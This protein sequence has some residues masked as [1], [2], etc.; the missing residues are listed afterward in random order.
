MDV[1]DNAFMFLNS[2]S[3]AKVML[4]ASWTEWKNLFSFEV[5]LESAKFE[6]KGLGGS[7]GTETLISHVMEG[8]L[9]IPTQSETLFEGPDLSWQYEL[10]DVEGEIMGAD[11][12]KGANGD[13]S[14]EVL[15]IVDKAYRFD[16]H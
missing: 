11:V 13:S 9:G 10:L 6:A 5:F 15:K 1:E 4:H 8:G 3:G 12:V 2:S 16:N 7:Y 14:V